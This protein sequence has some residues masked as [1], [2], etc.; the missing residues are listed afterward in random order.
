MI[1]YFTF[2][3]NVVFYV[4]MVGFVVVLASRSNKSVEPKEHKKVD[5]YFSWTSCSEDLPAPNSFLKFYVDGTIRRGRVNKFG[6][7]MSGNRVLQTGKVERWKY[8]L[9]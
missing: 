6:Q 2:I 1:A 3:G 7:F 8:A 5:H 9:I 4:F